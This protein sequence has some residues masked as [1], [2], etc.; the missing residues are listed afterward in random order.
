MAPSKTVSDGDR[1]AFVTNSLHGSHLNGSGPFVDD[2]PAPLRIAIV[3]AGI[4]G[5]TA[6]LGLRRNGHQVDLFEQSRFANEV[7]AAI[8]LAPNANGILRRW[9]I[10]AEEFGAISMDRLVEHSQDGSRLKN[11][12]LAMA[13]KRWQHP[14]HLVHRVNIHEK[15]KKLATSDKGGGIPAQLHTSS[16][17]ASIDPQ[18][19]IITLESGATATADVVIGADGI[20]S[21]S[22]KYI[23]DAR[24]F[25]SGKAAF[26]FLIPREVAEADPVTAPLVK[27][28]N[29]LE[30]WFGDDRRIV[31][32]PCND[33][34]LLNFV[35]IH[36]DTESHATKSD[37]WNKKA[38][39]EQ[40][41]KVYREFDPAV[42]A[43]ISKVD[44]LTLM[45][46]QLLDMEKLPTWTTGK[47]VLLGDAAHP[48]TPH[49]G[50]GAGQ[51]MED[52]AA[53]TTVLPKGTAPEA[54]SERLKLYEEIRSE[55]AH[56]IQQYSRLA[57]KDWENGV[58]AI[59]MMAYTNHNFGHD[60]I[61]YAA[62]IFKRWKWSKK[63]NMYWRMPVA[64]GPFPGPRQGEYGRRRLTDG[65]ARRFTTASIKFKTSRTFLETLFPTAQFRFKDPSTVA[66]A[67]FSATRLDNMAWLGGKGYTHFGLY[68]HGVQ[69]TKKDGTSIHGT[70]MPVL[71]E[72][73]TDPIVSGREEL[74]MP[75]LFA[76][77]DMEHDETSCR[78]TASWRGA[79]F[80]KIELPNLRK[81]ETTAEQGTIGGESDYGILVYRYIPAVGE[82]GKADAEYACVVPHSEESRVQ[83]STVTAVARSAGAKVKIEALDW[84]ALP[85]LH[86]ITSA[87]AEIP[88]YAVVDAKVVEGTGVSDVI[89]CRRI[90]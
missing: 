29:A 5:L 27:F 82:P 25:S 36:P 60:E 40:V 61:D 15:L 69:Y 71:F 81:D 87:L 26:R 68:V 33:N 47:L 64:F 12:D 55:R 19:G 44:P 75:K 8:H 43:L 57:G 30:I 39:I 90:E 67:S 38:T 62:N 13:N 88:I 76:D 86:H 45:V 48:F 49:Q 63:P 53:L 28:K 70:Y 66:T 1:V 3:G 73:L 83:S 56:A 77:I 17:V 32:Y 42:K 78:V 4:G 89:S 65:P 9:G 85:T 16:K 18:N 52:A 14:W 6:A 50:Q 37:E 23:K 79:T 74:G 24:L 2:H 59:D 10:F 51:A 46:W 72:S 7:G 84:E 35:C 21:M 11:I 20:Y 31:M 22:R 54:I 80:A 41:L 34:Q 58:P